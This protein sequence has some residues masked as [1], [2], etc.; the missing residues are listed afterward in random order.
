[1]R[2]LFAFVVLALPYLAKAQ[3]PVQSWPPPND[4]TMQVIMAQR[5][6]QYTVEQ[7]R[8]IML[9]PDGAVL[10]PIRVTQ[11]MLDTLDARQLDRRYH[12]IMSDAPASTS[13]GAAR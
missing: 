1:M 9:S 6:A 4:L 2:P 5:P 10:H 11:A 3:A 8:A 12:C 7:W 13:H